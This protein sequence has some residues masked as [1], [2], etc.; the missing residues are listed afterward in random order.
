MAKSPKLSLAQSQGK[1]ICDPK[2]ISESFGT[3]IS[4]AEKKFFMDLTIKVIQ[5]ESNFGD[6]REEEPIQP[7]PSGAAGSY[8]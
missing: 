3:T 2:G 1:I 6:V 4:K 8:V 5:V 7:I